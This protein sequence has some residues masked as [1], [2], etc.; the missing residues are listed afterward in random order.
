VRTNRRLSKPRIVVEVC[1]EELPNVRYIV[2]SEA[3]FARLRDW[4][5]HNHEIRNLLEAVAE[6]GGE[7]AHGRFGRKRL[8]RAA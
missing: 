3:D 8:R 2:Q 1:L 5:N 6:A 7:R 4:A